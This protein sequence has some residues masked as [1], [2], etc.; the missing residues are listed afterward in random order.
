MDELAP[1]TDLQAFLAEAIARHVAESPLNRLKDID[2]SPIFEA[3]LVG[4]A[5][6]DDPLFQLYKS[7]VG[8][9]HLTPREALAGP[10]GDPDAF[11]HVGVVVWTLPVSE[12]TV[13]SNAERSDGP[14]LRWNN[15]RFQGEDYNDALRAHV[16]GL[17]QER[18]HRAVAPMNAP[19]FKT[20]QLANG[21]ASNWS[22]RHIAYSAGLGTFSLTDAM[23]TAK[24]ITHRVGSAVTDAEFVP[25]PRPYTRPYEYLPRRG[26]WHLPGVH[27]PLPGRGTQ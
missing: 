9:F 23:I 27:R 13:R 7:V 20:L 14:S 25:T 3:P 1:M 26:G 24:G 2:G 17:L 18:G 12:V 19:Y 5:D 4:F 22:E 10:D 11:E 15:T 8:E 6:G 21:R 16:V